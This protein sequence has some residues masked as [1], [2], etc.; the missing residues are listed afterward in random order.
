MLKIALLTAPSDSKKELKVAIEMLENGLDILH[1]RKSKFSSK[2]LESYIKS[3]PIVFHKNIIIHSHFHLAS[4]YNLRGIHLSRSN[5]NWSFLFGV[6]MFFVK[7]FNPNCAYSSTFHSMET[8]LDCRLKLDHAVLSPVFTAI[9]KSNYVGGFSERQVERMR[10]EKPFP[11]YAL[12]GVS[13][14]TVADAISM[15]FDGVVMYG[16]IWKSS[17]DKLATFLEIKRLFEQRAYHLNKVSIKP[18]SLKKIKSSK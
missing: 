7:L 6:R 3:I 8:L 5:R 15:G 2:Q 9:S 10:E 16:T 12:G 4:K 11:V 1:L 13:T 14:E 18:L 17:E